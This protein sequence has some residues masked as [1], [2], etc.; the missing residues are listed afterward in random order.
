[1][2]SQQGQRQ[3]Y[4]YK[5]RY[6][7]SPIGIDLGRTALRA[8]QLRRRD[9][10]LHIHSAL[11]WGNDDSRNPNAC[12][13]ETLIEEE[14]QVLSQ[15]KR[16]R[17]CGGFVGRDVVIHCPAEK[18][19]IRPVNMPSGDN[20]LPREAVLGLL[21][22][23]IGG[24]VPFPTEQAVFDYLARPKDPQSKH[25]RIMA[26]TADGQWIKERIRWME[27]AGMHC[28]AVDALPCALA[29]VA[30]L[31]EKSEPSREEIDVSESVSEHSTDPNRRLNAVLD[32]GY[33]GSTLMVHDSHGPLFCRRFALGGREMTEILTHRLM[34]DFTQAEQFKRRF[35]MECNSRQLCLAG[36]ASHTREKPEQG[37]S[38]D[39][40]TDRSLQGSSWEHNRKIGKTIFAALQSAL[41]DYVEGLM[42]SLNYVITNCQ[43]A[44]LQNIYLAGAAAH[45]RNLDRYLT[46][47][48]ELPV[49]VISHP[50]LAEITCTLPATRAQTGNWTTAM[51]L[52]L[53]RMEIV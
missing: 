16:L 15:M 2:G 36:T 17:E 50:V 29:R 25:I 4:K 11:E 1:M 20:E 22:L 45:T 30:T 23:Q 14:S 35:G 44:R 24:H 21:R 34:I 5:H 41:R 37:G 19:D 26:V 13:Q 51:G 33:S 39:K 18:L 52:A 8:V 47:Q 10:T 9:G 31:C 40:E 42:R 43:G 32:I 48:F 3:K 6:K 12:T 28:I 46:G 7:Y 27:L 49:Q 53:K 38:D